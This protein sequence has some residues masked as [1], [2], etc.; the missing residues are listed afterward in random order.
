M[1]NSISTR[2]LWTGRVITGLAVLF[3]LFDGVIKFTS[4][5]AVAESFA[6]LGFQV[7]LA[8]TIGIIELA[9][10]AIYLAPRTSVFGAIL[11]TGYLGGAIAVQLRVANPLFS[12]V[13]FPTYVATLLWGGLYLR[14]NRVRALVVDLPTLRTTHQ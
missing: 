11:F 8:P 14:D 12:H 13:L 9:C 7:S 3:L 6:Q 2:R 10:L 4:V 5:P 1:S